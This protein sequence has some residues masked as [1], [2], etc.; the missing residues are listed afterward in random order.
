MSVYYLTR[1]QTAT[2]TAPGAVGG[3]T[4]VQA[5]YDATNAPV[6]SV[7]VQCVV[8]GSLTATVQLVGS[9]DGVNWES[10]GSAIAVTTGHAGTTVA[11]APWA[12]W[13]ALVTA[14]GT[15]GSVDTLMS[16]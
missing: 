8:T 6:G 10:Q 5:N 11:A 4:I 13:G 14:L 2:N 12:L 16:G 7:A 15:G 1:K 3:N 9:N